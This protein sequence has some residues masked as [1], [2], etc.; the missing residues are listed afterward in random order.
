MFRPI[1]RGLL[2]LQRGAKFL[3]AGDLYSEC[4]MRE[5]DRLSK[6]HSGEEL[7]AIKVHGLKSFGSYMSEQREWQKGVR[8]QIAE[9]VLWMAQYGALIINPEPEHDPTGF[10]GQIGISGGLRDHIFSIYR[11]KNGSVQP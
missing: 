10:R 1:A 3:E 11:S 9:S 2:R 8:H 5:V 7:E 6:Y 4:F